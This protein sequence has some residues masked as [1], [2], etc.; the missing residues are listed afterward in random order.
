M[1]SYDDKLF[2]SN[3]ELWM[4]QMHA[5]LLVNGKSMDRANLERFEHT[6]L[7]MALGLNYELVAQF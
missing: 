6:I 1:Y 4:L 2:N 7:H 5:Y 3:S